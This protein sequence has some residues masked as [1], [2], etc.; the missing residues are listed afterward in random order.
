MR[1][2][3]EVK[4]QSKCMS[5]FTRRRFLFSLGSAIGLSTRIRAASDQDW[6]LSFEDEIHQGNPDAPS[7]IVSF[8]HP[9][10]G[11]GPSYQE[12]AQ[13]AYDDPIDKT[14][15][16]PPRPTLFASRLLTIAED[17][18]RLG[19]SRSNEHK[20]Y[21]KQFLR[22]FGFELTL[23][24][25]GENVAFCAAG[26]C[27]AACRAYYES[28][29]RTY[30]KSHPSVPFRH[31]FPL[32]RE[33]FFLPN[34]MVR[35]IWGYARKV[36][37]D[38]VGVSTVP[39]PGWPVVFSFRKDGKPSHIG[40]VKDPNPGGKLTTV[41]F[42]TSKDDSGSQSDGGYVAERHRSRDLILGYIKLY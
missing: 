27:F 11:A 39:K 3:S 36:R 9:F 22:A 16:P 42:N 41:E 33:H 37:S 23:P 12:I 19:V 25:S 30:D 38:A 21:V 8:R 40:I 18:A 20:E 24:E 26:L 35:N 10:K 28:T 5:D 15:L 7:D 32:L 13:A 17:Y 14:L 4:R 2:R 6:Q 31:L 1:E 34:P 29:N